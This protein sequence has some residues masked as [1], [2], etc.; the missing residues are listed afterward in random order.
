MAQR[1][2]R[3][4]PRARDRSRNGDHGTPDTRTAGF[5]R[6]SP[7]QLSAVRERVQEIIEPVLAGAGYD[8]EDLA[9]RQTGR[10][11]Q[12]RITVDGDGGVNLDVIADL[13][14]AIADALDEAEAGGQEVIPGEYQL[15]VSSPGVDRPLTLPRHWRRAV[16]RMVSVKVPGGA[17][18][19][20]RLT[21]AG[22]TGVTLEIPE[23]KSVRTQTYPLSELGPGHVQ[24]EFHRLDEISDEDLVE[25]PDDAYADDADGLG[26]FHGDA[27]ENEG[28]DDEDVEEQ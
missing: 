10:R 16:G 22:A 9:V 27:D 26:E 28:A 4:T 18:V 15:E 21:A 19:T 3:D 14:R 13:S 1:N 25:I 17:L 5:E 12:L 6:R 7:A 8:L 24:I 11:H 20:G 2:R 23:R